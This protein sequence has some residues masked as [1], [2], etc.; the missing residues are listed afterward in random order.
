MLID[1]HSSEKQFASEQN[2]AKII[3]I[4]SSSLG[5]KQSATLVSGVLSQFDSLTR[6]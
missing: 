4:T 2:T 1:S 5:R 3:Q 6:T